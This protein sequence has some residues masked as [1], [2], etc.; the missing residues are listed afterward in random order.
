MTFVSAR[1]ARFAKRCKYLAFRQSSSEFT[2][3][4]EAS[5]LGGVEWLARP[6]ATSLRSEDHEDFG[7]T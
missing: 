1:L 2:E 6:S 4:E 3:A 5:S 7:G